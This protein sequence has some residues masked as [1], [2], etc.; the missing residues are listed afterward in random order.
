MPNGRIPGTDRMLVY[1][2]T[3]SQ[4]AESPRTAS[5]LTPAERLW[6]QDRQDAA[7]KALQDKGSEAP[8]MGALSASQGVRLR[9]R[10]IR[11]LLQGCRRAS[12]RSII[13][14]APGTGLPHGY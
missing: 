14:D 2:A 4:L 12:G 9:L 5:F 7:R 1:P 11:G 3:Q 6:L 10:F 13:C 8:A